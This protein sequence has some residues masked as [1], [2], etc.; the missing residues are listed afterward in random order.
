MGVA[1]TRFA[2]WVAAC[3]SDLP[4]GFQDV[5]CDTGTFLAPYSVRWLPLSDETRRRLNLLGLRTLGQFAALS[6]T[7]IGEQFGPEALR[8][9]RWAR[10][11]D[12]G[13]LMGRRRQVLEARLYF[14]EPEARREPLLDA[15]ERGLRQMLAEAD[16]RA[17]TMQRL[18][19]RLPGEGAR[20]SSLW[21]GEC[22]AGG[23]GLA[24]GQMRALLARLLDNLPR[25]ELEEDWGLSEIILTVTGLEPAQG[26]QLDL[27]RHTAE[28]LQ[29][30]RTLGELAR[31]HPAGCV[32][33]VQS[34]Q[35]A[36]ALV[37]DRYRL[38]AY[39]P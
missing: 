34:G 19:L 20:E 23:E 3:T 21:V 6:P 14:E 8:F 31:K 25:D 13:P 9:H 5:V 1:G 7:A 26:R 35:S 18:G 38:E 32:A 39:T 12:D 4:P 17:L 16:A 27:F 15:L 28:G 30:E 29:L 36:A 10:G 33:R 24:P 22:L 11:Q 37:A 2:T